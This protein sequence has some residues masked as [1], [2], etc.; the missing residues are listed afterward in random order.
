MLVEKDRT[1]KY[2]KYKYPIVVI[3][4]QQHGFIRLSNAFRRYSNILVTCSIN[5]LIT[6][7]VGTGENIL[8]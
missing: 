8:I 4:I 3:N 1:L 2:E 6:N 7:Q 5:I